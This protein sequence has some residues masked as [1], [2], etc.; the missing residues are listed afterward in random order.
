MLTLALRLRAQP[1]LSRR[2]AILHSLNLFETHR[3]D[4]AID[5]F[6]SLD[7]NPARVVALYPRAISGKLFL[8]HS[9]HEEAFGGRPQHRVAAAIEAEEGR[10]REE[11]ER[12]RV[13][14][15]QEAQAKGS[16]APSSPSKRVKGPVAAAAAAADDDDAAS[17]RTVGSRLGVKR[18][19][20]RER[21]A[22][23]TLDEIAEQ[24]ASAC[25]RLSFTLFA[26]R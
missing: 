4:L 7:L 19:W 22:S 9:A 24:A 12:R 25:L 26:R 5:A 3:Y 10:Q 21:D 17:I 15:E 16:P 6:I 11:E 18:S 8:E 13:E 2:L 20:L 14:R 1:P 23:A